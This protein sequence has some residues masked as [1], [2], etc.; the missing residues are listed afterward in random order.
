LEA[1]SLPRHPKIL[2]IPKAQSRDH[3][4]SLRTYQ[5]GYSMALVRL[6]ALTEPQSEA[7]RFDFD[8]HSRNAAE[9]YGKKRS[10]YQEFAQTVRD[11]LADSVKGKS[12]RVN[13]IQFRAKEIE[14]FGKKAMTPSDQRPEEPKYKNP[15]A[16]ITD[17]A[18]VR[19]ITFFPRTVLD[20]CQCIEEEFEVIEKVDH[21]AASQKQEKLGYQSIHYLAKFKANRTKLPEYKRFDGLVAEIQVRTVMQHAWAEIEHDIRY[22]S[23]SAI[24]LEI[25]RRF[26]TLAGL[27]EIADREFEAIQEQD[28]QLR[29]TAV[30]KLAAGKFAEV[31]ITPDALRSYLGMTLGYDE[32]ISDFSYD[33]DARLL[34]G[35]GF[36]NF[37]QVDDCVRGL[38]DD[39]LS[40]QAWGNRS[41]QLSRFE[42]ML[43]VSMGEYFIEN[44]MWREYEGYRNAM[45]GRLERLKEKGVTIG[46]YRPPRSD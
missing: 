20:V 14:S 7:P 35:L 15:L 46:S 37:Q 28:A 29:E 27:L 19:V 16:E 22:K 32:R 43:Q 45:N 23:A 24:P 25:S 2:Q 30:T 31:E 41:G 3:I 40:R 4:S 11:I 38:D 9:Q 39:Y 26:M 36:Q 10:K 17:M 34:K 44:H 8:A 12:L 6:A 33:P 5:Y 42:L 21:I 18:G 1:A 13:D